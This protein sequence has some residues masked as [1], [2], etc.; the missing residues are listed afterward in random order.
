MVGKFIFTIT[1]L[2]SQ[3]VLLLL[4]HQGS[5]VGASLDAAEF[6]NAFKDS[7]YWDY[8]ILATY[9]AYFRLYGVYSLF[10]VTDF[11]IVEK[12]SWRGVGAVL[13]PLNHFF[14]FELRSLNEFFSHVVTWVV[15]AACSL[16]VLANFLLCFMS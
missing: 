9:D 5:L 7:G 8:C 2:V 6:E 12:A 3:R 1:W 10:V 4:R 11:S 16:C 13:W 14:F 15:T